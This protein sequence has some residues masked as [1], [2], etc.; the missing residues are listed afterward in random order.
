MASSRNEKPIHL[1]LL[2][3]FLSA[4]VAMYTTHPFDTIKIQYQADKLNRRVPTLVS[5]IYKYQGLSGFFKGCGSTLPTYPIFWGLFFAIKDNKH[6][7]SKWPML[8]SIIKTFIASTIASVIC[9]PLF[10]L[11]TRKQTLATKDL[12]AGS[13]LQE[14]KSIYLS[15][16]I[17]GFG[18][19]LPVTLWSNFRLIFQFPL[20][21]WLMMQTSGSILISSVVSKVTANTLFYPTNIIGTIQRD[22]L[23]K[24]T[25]RSCIKQLYDTHGIKGFYRGLL[26][27]NLSSGS[28][29]T[30][31]MFTKN[32]I[33]QWY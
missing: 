14:I 17:R 1:Q 12:K 28:N 8:N 15:D 29:F 18:K 10:V 20:Y 26:L 2:S 27:Y 33:D 13:Y 4:T 32:K 31:M 22:Y 16:G 30:V 11:K 25:I 24:L 9:N 7:V 6:Q 3:G 19:G 21:E 23:E 5:N